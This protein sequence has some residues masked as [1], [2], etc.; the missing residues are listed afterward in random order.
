M[1]LRHLDLIRYGRFTD[2]QLHFGPGGGETDV[3]IVYGENEAGKSTAFSAWLDLLFGLPLQHPYDFVHARKDLLVGATLDTNEGPLTL[4]RTGQRQGSLT[5]EN[6]RMMDERRLALLLHGLDRD[7]YRTRFSLDDEVLRQGGEEI[8]RAKG[9]LGQLLH[10]GSSGLSGFADLLKQAE[11]EVAA[12]HKRRGRTTILAEGRNRLKEL[13]EA[14][15]QARLDP[16]RFDALCREVESAEQAFHDATALRDDAKRRLALREAADCRRD[17]GGRID[18]ARTALEGC[19][20]GP[21]LPADALTRVSVAVDAAA[22][23]EEAKAEAEAE[24]A[25]AERLLS[26]LAPDPEGIAVGEMLAELE[27]AEF[28]DGESL[29]ARASLADADLGRRRLEWD[30]ARAEGRRLAAALAGDGA[31]PAEVV[32]PR[33]VR[34]GI[35]EAAQDVRETARSRDQAQNALDDASA[36]LGEVEEMPEGAEVLADALDTL[37]ALRDDP[38]AM[39]RDLKEREAEAR[40]TAT[41]LPPGWRALT[42]AGLP[43]TAELREA[44]RALKAVDDK[45]SAAEERLHE[46]QEKLADS[47]TE[48]EGERLAASVVTDDEIAATRV[49]RERLWTSH[50]SA[51]E[52][53][54]ADAFEAAMRGDD[55]ARGRHARSAEGRVRLARMEADRMA[56]A[57]GVER[58]HADVETARKKRIA[59]LEEAYRLATRLGLGASVGP[60][61]FGERLDALKVALDDALSAEQ[62]MEDLHAAQKV[63]SEAEDKVLHAAAEIAGDPPSGQD[64][65]AAARRLRTALEERRTRIASRQESEKLV[66]GFETQRKTKEKAYADAVAAY[67]ARVSGLWCA[68]MGV[69]T[70]LRISDDLAELAELHGK[71]RD[72]DRR[73]GLLEAARAAF[74]KRAGPLRDKLG[75]RQDTPVDET[76]RLARDRARKATETASRIEETRKTRDKAEKELGRQARAAER[77]AEEIATVFGGQVIDPGDDPLAALQRLLDRDRLRSGI[78]ELE[79]ERAKVAEGLDAAVLSE[80]E[81]DTDPIRTATLREAVGEA[82]AEREESIGRRGEARQALSAALGTDGGV[83]QGQARAALLEELREAARRAAETQI[84][85]MA[86]SGA[87][88]RLREDRRGPMLDS[89]ERA[90]ARM[91]GGE[92]S[93]LEAQPAGSGERLVGIRD[94][95]P[96]SAEAMS[97]GTRGQL[98]LALRVAGHADFTTRYGALPFVTDDILESFDDTRASAALSLTAEM[99]RTGQA[100]MFTHHRHL[101]DMALEV[102]PD[103]HVVELE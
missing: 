14:L 54:T 39:A 28:D 62:A 99:G 32:L 59:P 26:D 82:E 8:A 64:A 35:R 4:R 51:L 56:V 71:M 87:L 17:L 5:D 80:E 83:D 84:G 57:A 25:K 1:R 44:E 74:D 69:V 78:A 18:E 24:I 91:T 77:T 86:A 101:V 47:D 3:T 92:W 102:I 73:V 7:G 93:R 43:T 33:E 60:S 23:A 66:R 52:P 85:L 70:V 68:Q 50:R 46:A 27:A 9:D 37:D 30:T 49:E 79:A 88:R 81:A 48:L 38:E 89:A 100:I 19:P 98:Y 96:V 95:Q 34:N 103:L 90:F 75:V 20:E 11:G 67:E 31:D 6:G 22:R 58:R 94:G 63:R 42:D 29:M 53:D 16:R 45:I 12:F 72:L 2:R 76:L 10:A 15:S 41:G 13:D 55:D 65:V 21:T 61:V 40:R 97:T 36:E